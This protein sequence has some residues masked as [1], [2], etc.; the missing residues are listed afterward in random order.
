M[1]TGDLAGVFSYF[2]SKEKEKSDEQ[3]SAFRGLVLRRLL[4]Y[5]SWAQSKRSF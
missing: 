5:S 2:V 3:L 1:R 4:C